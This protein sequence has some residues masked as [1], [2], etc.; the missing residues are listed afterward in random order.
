MKY[1]LIAGGC[2]VLIFLIALSFIP[3][4]IE[5]L[6][7]LYFENHTKLPY[8]LFLNKPYNF[9]F[10]VHNLEYMDMN[11]KYEI[12][13]EYDNKTSIFD[14]GIFFLENNQSKQIYESFSMNE[15]F[16][17]AKVSVRLEK[18]D[19]NPMQ[20]D[21]NLKNVPLDLHFWVEAITGPTITITPD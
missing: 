12:A 1:V 6:T 3:I 5:P 16:D 13:A 20:K 10:T 18:L 15:R 21:P 4:G 8:L 7:E 19:E 2:I 14:S 9:S 11:Y 17:T